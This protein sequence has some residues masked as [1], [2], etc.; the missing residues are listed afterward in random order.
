MNYGRDSF[1][2]D[3]GPSSRNQMQWD[4]HSANSSHWPF[5]SSDQK[6]WTQPPN[7]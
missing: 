5:D 6:Y 3:S 1:Q 4:M 7:M 2:N